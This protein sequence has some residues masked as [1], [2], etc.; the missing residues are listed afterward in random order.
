MDLYFLRRLW[1]AKGPQ[2]YRCELAPETDSQ[3]RCKHATIKD[4]FKKMDK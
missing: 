2:R 3:Q 4:V 1:M